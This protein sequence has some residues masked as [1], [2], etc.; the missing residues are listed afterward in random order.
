[1]THLSTAVFNLAELAVW[2]V[3]SRRRILSN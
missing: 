1:M 3:M 2:S